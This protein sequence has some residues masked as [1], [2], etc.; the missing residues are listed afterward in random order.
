MVEEARLRGCSQVFVR[1]THPELS[2]GRM[3]VVR[4]S[5]HESTGIRVADAHL[6][7]VP[8]AKTAIN[9]ENPTVE[10]VRALAGSS[11]DDA[12]SG[13]RDTGR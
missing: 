2:K 13:S 12:W 8:M 4:S 6:I 7:N 3:A 10:T 1:L 5:G 9:A 11:V